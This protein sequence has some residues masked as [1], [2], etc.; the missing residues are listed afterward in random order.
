MYCKVDIIGR[1]SNDLELLYTAKG[2][3]VCNF[4][5]A[6]D[7]GWGDKKETIFMKVVCFGKQ[8]ESVNQ[9]MTKG[10][11]L[12]VSGELKENKWEKDGQKHIRMEIIADKVKFLGSKSDSQSAPDEA[13]EAESF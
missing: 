7:V 6:F 5:I 10:K 9:Y 1:I 4:N 11:Q 8:A 12:F 13:S 2:T 3:A